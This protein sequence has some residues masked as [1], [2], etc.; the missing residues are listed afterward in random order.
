MV[1]CG[2]MDNFFFFFE[3]CL[4]IGLIW[5]FCWSMNGIVDMFVCFVIRDF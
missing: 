1:I 3:F 4:K 2:S 5:C